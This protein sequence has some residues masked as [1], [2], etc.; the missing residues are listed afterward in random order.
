MT[1]GDHELNSTV[2]EAP[3]YLRA[4]ATPQRTSGRQALVPP[5]HALR[6]LDSRAGVGHAPDDRVPG[7][8]S[9]GDGLG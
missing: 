1:D 4:I 5:D 8:K 2:D 3:A 9:R 6:A 7:R